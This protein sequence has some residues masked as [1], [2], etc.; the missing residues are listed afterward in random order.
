MIFKIF[1]SFKKNKLLFIKKLKSDL[2]L[3]EIFPDLD[4]DK[5]GAINYTEF[6]AATIDKTVYLKNERL[7]EAFKNF[8]KDGSGKISVKE[9]ST[10]IHAQNED[11]G[12][13]E[14]AVKKFD[15][16]G[17]GEIDYDEFC[18]MMGNLNA[19]GEIK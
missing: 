5:S 4:T 9:I 10:I 2:N 7:F 13:I 12:S 14:A 6:L 17:D 16:N 11:F 15:L 1:S 8:D 19:S 3:Q 18:N